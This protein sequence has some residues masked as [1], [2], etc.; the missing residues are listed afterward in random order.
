M[1][2]KLAG[3]SDDWAKGTA[4]IKYAYTLELAPG[5]SG[6]DSQYGFGKKNNFYSLLILNNMINNII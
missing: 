2:G 1:F 4:N 3:V 5:D 6:V